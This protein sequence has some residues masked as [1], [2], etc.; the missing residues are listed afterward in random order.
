MNQGIIRF[1][2]FLNL[3]FLGFYKLC[4]FHKIKVAKSCMGCLLHLGEESGSS[5]ILMRGNQLL[6][7]PPGDSMVL[8]YVMKLLFSEKSPNFVKLNNHYSHKNHQIWNP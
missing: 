3:W 1:L 2:R 7:L 8:N 4:D 5:F 6:V